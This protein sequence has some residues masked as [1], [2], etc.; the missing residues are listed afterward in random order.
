MRSGAREAMGGV[1]YG[2][3]RPHGTPG[4]LPGAFR[5]KSMDLKARETCV[6]WRAVAL[7]G[8][9]HAIAGIIRG[10]K[11]G[12]LCSPEQSTIRPIRDGPG[13]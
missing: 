5:P 3:F 2:R 1:G 13:T 8:A 7:A 12:L 11:A 10:R 9:G 4:C 6:A